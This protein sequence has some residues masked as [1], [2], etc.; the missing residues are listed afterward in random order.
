M[1]SY[2]PDCRGFELFTTIATPNSCH[3]YKS[4]GY[5]ITRIS[6]D[7]IGV[8]LAYFAKRNHNRRK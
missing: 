4:L 1:E 7:K 3:L 2:F 6:Q 8:M 5:E